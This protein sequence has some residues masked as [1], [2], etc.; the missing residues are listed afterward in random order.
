MFYCTQ[1]CNIYLPSWIL[2]EQNKMIKCSSF[3]KYGSLLQHNNCYAFFL[4]GILLCTSPQCR[5]ADSRTSRI[6]VQIYLFLMRRYLYCV[7]SRP[8]LSIT[9][10]FDLSLRQK[11]MNGSLF[12]ISAW[13]HQVKVRF[14]STNLKSAVATKS[15]TTYKNRKNLCH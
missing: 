2:W 10:I 1:Q 14:T 5:C 3:E 8:L 6:S 4:Q 12:M 13:I 7:L 9:Q 15:D 11:S